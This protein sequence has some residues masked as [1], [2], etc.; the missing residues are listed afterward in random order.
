V[1]VAR[2]EDWQFAYVALQVIMQVVVTELCASL[3]FSSADALAANPTIDNA[4]KNRMV[5][6]RMNT[7]PLLFPLTRNIRISSVPK[8][9]PP[10][11]RIL[12]FFRPFYK[13]AARMAE[14]GWR[15]QPVDATLYLASVGLVLSMPFG[16]AEMPMPS[17]EGI[18]R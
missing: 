10:Q 13:I 3:N 8:M 14:L 15:F 6:P 12:A 17:D 4:A 18:G 2:H 1:P 9:T 11:A 5:G 7:A 16:A